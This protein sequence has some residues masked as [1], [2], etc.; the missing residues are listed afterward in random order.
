MVSLSQ[1]CYRQQ[2]LE[3]WMSAD[4]DVGKAHI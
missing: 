1:F 2:S 3:Q 4:I